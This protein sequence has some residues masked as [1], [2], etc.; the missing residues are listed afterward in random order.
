MANHLEVHPVVRVIP[1]EALLHQV[2][3]EAEV[4]LAEAV[5]QMVEAAAQPADQKETNESLTIGGTLRWFSF[6]NS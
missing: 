1:V 3:A 2:V 6:Y 5:V 4:Q